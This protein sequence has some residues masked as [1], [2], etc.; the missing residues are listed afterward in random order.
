MIFSNLLHSRFQ[1][2]SSSFSTSGNAFSIIGA[3]IGSGGGFGVSQ[4]SQT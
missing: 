4:I 2:S 3:A 1:I